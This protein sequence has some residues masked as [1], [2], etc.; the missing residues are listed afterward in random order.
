MP[1]C[2]N[3]GNQVSVPDI[4]CAKCGHR[5]PAAPKP[6]GVFSD[7]PPRTASLLCYIP[8]VGWLPAIIVL[9]SQR[10]RQDRAVRFHAFQ[11]IYLF[12]AWLLVDEVIRPMFHFGSEFH[13]LFVGVSISA[14]LKL[15]LLAAWIVMLVKTSQDEF[16]SLPIIGELAERSVAGR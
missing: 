7:M 2:S 5:Q 10:F 14:I 12:V 4:Y 8:V 13:F 16:Y 9:A 1:Y 15:L 3:C 11:G 6:K